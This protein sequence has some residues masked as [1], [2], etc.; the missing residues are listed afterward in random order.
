MDISRV[1]FRVAVDDVSAAE[2]MWTALLGTGPTFLDPSGWAQYDTPGGRVVL[3]SGNEA[4]GGN[5]L[6]F[7]VDDLERWRMALLAQGMPASP[8]VAGKHEQMF[9]VSTPG[10]HLLYYK[11]L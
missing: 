4:S 9:S 8:V 7:K 3:A 10:L 6:L 11:S 2:G 5:A 1:A